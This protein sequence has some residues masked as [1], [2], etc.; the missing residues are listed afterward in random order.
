[1]AGILGC[2]R[3]IEKIVKLS[4]NSYFRTYII[5]HSSY[6]QSGNRNTWQPERRPAIIILPGGGY[7]YIA[8]S[9]DEPV[10]Y[11]FLTKGYSCFS[12]HYSVGD[13]SVYPIPLYELFKTIAYIRQNAIDWGIDSDAIAVCGFSAGAHLAGLGA[14]QYHIESVQQ[15]LNLEED[16]IKPNAAILCYPITNVTKLNDENPKRIASWGM[17]LK[18]VDIRADVVAYVS[19]KMCPIFLWHTRTDGIVPVSQSIELI[20]K[21]YIN[22]VKFESHIFGEGYHGLST[23]DVLSNYKGAIQNGIIVPNVE[24]WI[25]MCSKWINNLFDFNNVKG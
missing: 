14:T 10:I 6:I 21:M 20:E 22:N 13:K 8:D 5:E 17:M 3:M 25:N 24:L 15:E 16:S 11:H 19:D 18:N 12:L 9:E 23:N 2:D 4:E 7:Q 1:M